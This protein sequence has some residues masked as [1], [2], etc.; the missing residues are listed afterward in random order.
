M[1]YSEE[2]VRCYG[3]V[4]PDGSQRFADPLLTHRH[5][6]ASFRGDIPQICRELNGDNPGLKYQATAA[7]REAVT[8]AFGLAP[9][10]EAAGGTTAAYCLALLDDFLRWC[11]KKNPGGGTTSDSSSPG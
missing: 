1:E 7:V 6:T 4:G 10:S 3:Y 8:E 5:L 11:E 9:F 2:Q